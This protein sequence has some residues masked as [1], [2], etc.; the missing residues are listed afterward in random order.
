MWSVIRV[1][2]AVAR[3][4]LA[5]VHE[6][7]RDAAASGVRVDA[8]HPDVRLVGCERR[9]RRRRRARRARAWR[10][11]GSGR[12]PRPRRARASGAAAGRDVGD[13]PE[14]LLPRR[15]RPAD[16]LAV[17]ERGD[18]RPPPRTPRAA[19]R[20]P[21]TAR[22]RLADRHATSSRLTTR[23]PRRDDRRVGEPDLARLLL[24]ASRALGA[25]VVADLDERGFPDARPGHAAVFMHIDRRSGTRLTDLAR[26]ARMTKQGMMLRRR[27]SRDARVRPARSA[28]PR[29]PARRSSGSPLA[30]GGTSRRPAGRSPPSRPARGASSATG[31]TSRSASALDE[32]IEAGERPHGA[33][34]VADPRPSSPCC[35]T[36]RPSRA[37]APSWSPTT[38]RA[39]IAE[40]GRLL[41]RRQRRPDA[42]APCSA[43]SRPSTCRGTGS[44]SGRS[45]SAWRRTATRTGTSPACWRCC[46]RRRAR[47]CV[48]CR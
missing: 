42:R 9:D 1:R 44:G 8:E 20:G 18:P 21:R 27:R 39:A 4:V 45:T 29:T 26:R 47:T 33:L 15:P 41:A 34:S 25:E 10:C 6:R 11:R 38:A 24:E 48:R 32:L 40:R 13:L 31:G 12:P 46:R 35:P 14:V 19:P 16:E 30:A 7:S 3:A 43:T 23:R 5:G 2:P 37:G 17:G 28:T 36:P 22:S